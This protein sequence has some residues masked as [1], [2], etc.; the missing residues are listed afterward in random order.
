MSEIIK[1]NQGAVLPPPKPGRNLFGTA[2]NAENSIFQRDLPSAPITAGDVSRRNDSATRRAETGKIRGICS[3]GVL[4]HFVRFDNLHDGHF[5]NAVRVFG[6]PDYLHRFWDRRALREID[7]GDIVLFAK[8][9]ADQPFSAFPA[10]D[11]AY[12]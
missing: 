3:T 7:A 6:Q 1:H 8:G 9:D 12:Q 10:N 11:E 2:E 5:W 4:V